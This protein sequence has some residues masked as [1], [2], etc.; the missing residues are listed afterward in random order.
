MSPGTQPHDLATA[1]ITGQMLSPAADTETDSFMT[2][3]AF[4]KGLHMTTR[5][6]NVMRWLAFCACCGGGFG[7][8]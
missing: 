5:T 7:P 8:C 4:K 2:R 1:C 6:Y 3:Q